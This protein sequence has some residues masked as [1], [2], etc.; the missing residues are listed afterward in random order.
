MLSFFKR[1]N[2]AKEYTDQLQ[3]IAEQLKEHPPPRATTPPPKRAVGRPKLKRPAAEVLADVAAAEA[4]L[5]GIHQADKKKHR[6]EYSLRWFDSGFM[7]AIILAHTRCGG[8]ARKTVSTL[9]K[10]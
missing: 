9:Q 10:S 7:A 1:V 5:T 8:S 3:L 6:G 4:V 2:D